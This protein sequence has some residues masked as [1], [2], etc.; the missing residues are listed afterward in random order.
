MLKS[1]NYYY[2][3]AYVILHLVCVCVCVCV[4]CGWLV[5]RGRSL[6]LLGTITPCV[7]N[8]YYFLFGSLYM[9]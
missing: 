3:L 4:C 5:A 1:C 9:R 7:W 6:Y 2:V 8:L